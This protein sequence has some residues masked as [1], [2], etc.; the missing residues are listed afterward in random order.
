ME[1]SILNIDV[2]ISI[3]HFI[4]IDISFKINLTVMQLNSQIT[5]KVILDNFKFIRII[6]IAESSNEQHFT[7]LKKKKTK[8]NG[9]KN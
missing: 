3:N 6:S 4:L 7:L 2:I 9:N 1:L 8:F 5:Q